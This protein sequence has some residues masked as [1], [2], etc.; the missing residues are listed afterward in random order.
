MKSY[1]GFTPEQRWKALAWYKAEMKAGRIPAPSEC[2]ACGQKRG[3]IDYHA[4]DYSEPFGPHV[5]RFQL[6]FLCHMMVHCRF[7]NDVAFLSYVQAVKA[8]GQF[9]P[10]NDFK[11]FAS[12]YLNGKTLPATDVTRA[13][14]A[15]NVLA[16]IAA[17]KYRP[18][19][20]RSYAPPKPVPAAHRPDKT[21]MD[22]IEK[23]MTD[24]PMPGRPI[25][26]YEEGDYPND[27]LF[28]IAPPK[29][30]FD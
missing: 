8:G 22:S 15:D 1:N 9:P 29:R 13:A 18:K 23:A 21:R 10:E 30:R 16:D 6:C 7:G 3:R 20:A 14:P 2:C 27:E 4:E 26:Q 25:D 5:V 28:P 11:V 17:G 12:K 24:P 19:A